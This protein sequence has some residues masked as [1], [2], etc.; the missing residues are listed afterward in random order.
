MAPKFVTRNPSASSFFALLTCSNLEHSYFHSLLAHR[1]ITFALTGEIKFFTS[2]RAD[3]SVVGGRCS[4]FQCLW[5]HFFAYVL[6]RVDGKA[7]IL[8][9]V[10][11][12]SGK[13]NF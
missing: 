1:I 13:N 10:Y 5:P 6:V 2:D 8:S 11:L 9:R 7:R 3:Y 4:G 12:Q